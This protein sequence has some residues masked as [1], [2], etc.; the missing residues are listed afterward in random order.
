MLFHLP[1]DAGEERNLADTEPEQLERMRG[2][3]LEK[4]REIDA[5][6]ELL[7]R[8]GLENTG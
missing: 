1:S 2:V 6:G 3:L 4:L 5:P 8:L 7:S